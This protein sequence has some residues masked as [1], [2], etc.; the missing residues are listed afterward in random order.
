MGMWEKLG[1]ERARMSSEIE[2]GF[3]VFWRMAWV[4]VAIFDGSL[5]LGRTVLDFQVGFE[6]II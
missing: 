6:A 4:N 2:R 5:H 3:L 1:R